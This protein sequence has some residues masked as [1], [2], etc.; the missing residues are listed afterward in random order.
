MTIKHVTVHQAHARQ[1]GGAVYLDVRSVPEFEQG[2][3]TGA[4]NV[5]LLHLDPATGLMQPNPD[6]LPV[7]HASFSPDAPLLL[8]CRSGVRSQHACE[9]LA[10]AGYR[11]LANVLGGFHGS[12]QTGEAGWTQEGLPVE[13]ESDPSRTYGAL[14]EKAAGDR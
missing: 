2:H 10:S 7:V 8:G 14:R 1:A 9:L 6:F 4:F 3:P 11:D 12:P 5:P 13:T